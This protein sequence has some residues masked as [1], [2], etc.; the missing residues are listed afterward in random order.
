MSMIANFVQVTPDQLAQLLADPSSVQELFAV[1]A[2]FLSEDERQWLE[3]MAEQRY[4]EV[5]ARKGQLAQEFAAMLEGLDP[6]FRP[7]VE[8]QLAA[9]GVNVADLKGDQ[10][11]E[12][13]LKYMEETLRPLRAPPA[14]SRSRSGN[15]GIGFSL[16]KAFH[17]VHYLLCGEVEAG[18]SLLGQAILGGAELGD[19]RGYG[20][21]RFF[22]ADRVAQ[23]AR[24]MSRPDL[25]AEMTARFDPE[26]MSRLGIYPT[27]WN[28][29]AV[30]GLLWEFRRLRDFYVGA[31]AGGFAVVT[32]IV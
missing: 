21:A 25:E 30:E 2:D 5:E 17:G 12:M 20:P 26:V 1:P 13:M 27:P 4:Q 8:Q 14:S 29:E 6:A 10:G 16:E 22:P 18:K 3:Q 7:M 24:E 11:G 9:Q 19:D 31:A 28:R 23:I 32:C 15:Q